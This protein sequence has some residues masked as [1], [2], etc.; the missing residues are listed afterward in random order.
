MPG[1][2]GN[3]ENTFFPSQTTHQVLILIYLMH[4]K[5]N[6]TK[7]Q[8]KKPTLNIILNVKCFHHHM[9]FTT[10]YTQSDSSF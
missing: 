1:N 4:T 3:N 10:F 2:N 6:K 5:Q 8:N 9:Y 7:L